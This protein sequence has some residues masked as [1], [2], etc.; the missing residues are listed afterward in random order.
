MTPTS[1]LCDSPFATFCPSTVPPPPLLKQ[2]IRARRRRRAASLLTPPP[3]GDSDKRQNK[4]HAL[5]M[6]C[7]A[8]FSR[9]AHG[10][11]STGHGPLWRG[12]TGADVKQRIQ[13]LAAQVH[14]EQGGGGCSGTGSAS[15]RGRFLLMTNAEAL[16]RPLTP[17]CLSLRSPWQQHD[18]IHVSEYRARGRGGRLH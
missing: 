15:W 12:H 18:L 16:K 5:A 11:H 13:W 14:I 6:T 4:Q 17:T 1:F 9:C 8:I 10:V 2:P 7:W 3:D